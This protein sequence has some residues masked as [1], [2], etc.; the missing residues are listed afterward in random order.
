VRFHQ[1]IWKRVYGVF[2]FASGSVRRGRVITL[3]RP[4]I[5]SAFRVTLVRAGI[6]WLDTGG[7]ADAGF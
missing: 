6:A 2:G 4:I 5:E 3:S 7:S 1:P